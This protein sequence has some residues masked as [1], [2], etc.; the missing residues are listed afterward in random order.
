[1]D[2]LEFPSIGTEKATWLE[3]EFELE[4]I[5]RAVLDLGRDSTGT[6]WLFNRFFSILLGRCEGEIM[7]F[8]KEFYSRGKLSLNLGATFIALIPKK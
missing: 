6:G 7:E 5:K 3:R 1:M 8:M 4:E 2:N